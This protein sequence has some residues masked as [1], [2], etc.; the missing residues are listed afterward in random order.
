MAHCA[1]M[2]A[3]ITAHEAAMR[4]HHPERQ[5]IVFSPELH[6]LGDRLKGAVGGHCRRWVARC[7]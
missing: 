1:G 3:K 4:A 2:F 5:P 7:D 6:G